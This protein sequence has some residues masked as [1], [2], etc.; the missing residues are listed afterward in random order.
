MRLKNGWVAGVGLTMLWSVSAQGIVVVTSDTMGDVTPER[1]HIGV[2]TSGGNSLRLHNVCVSKGITRTDGTP[3]II[4]D[5]DA[6]LNQNPALSDQL[7]FQRW[8]VTGGNA[9]LKLT[10]LGQNTGY[11]SPLKLYTYGIN[12]TIDDAVVGATLFTTNVTPAG[13]EILFTVPDNHY[14]GFVLYANGAVGN[15]AG[16]YWTENSKNTDNAPGRI[17]DHFLMYNIKY[18][19][20]I[21]TMIV[22]EDLGYNSSPQQFPNMLGDQDYN[23]V[24]VGMLTFADDTPI[25]E[26][27]S[28]GLLALGALG[29]LR[30]R[31][32]A[33]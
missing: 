19:G 12:Q 16:V 14:F 17:T 30:R 29:L 31:R 5:V 18:N 2:D 3:L 21:S 28:L 4:G 23:D 25:P 26:P 11:N 10:Y 1:V 8:R 13:T 6:P 24:L 9:D 27:G 22:A 20:K 15:P 33:A 7:Q 32:V